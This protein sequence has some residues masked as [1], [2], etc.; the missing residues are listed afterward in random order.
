[1]KNQAGWSSLIQQAQLFGRRAPEAE[2]TLVIPLYGRWEFLRGHVAGFAM[3][4]WFQQGRVRLLYVCDDPRLHLLQRWCAM[5]LAHEALDISVISLRRN[6]GFGMA[7]NIG[8]QAAETPL[9]CL[10][11]SDIMPMAPGWLEPMHQRIRKQP[12]QLLA[13]LLLYDTGLIQHAGMVTEVQ[14]NGCRG[15]P[16]NIHPYKGLS[17]QELEQVHPELEPYPVDS[18][19][20][21]MLL[22]ERDR[23]LA[24]GGFHPAFGRGD[25]EDLEK[26]EK[27]WY[28]ICMVL[29]DEIQKHMQMTLS[30]LKTHANDT[31]CEQSK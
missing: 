9:V 7:C 18:L 22:F 3:D 23:F 4:P 13:P 10:M 12:E 14:N 17:L 5:H 26:I 2:I 6:M 31:K 16:A 21:A 24:I 1:M 20:A 30:I 19:S 27:M 11:N 8:V 25:F 28:S 15:F 29:R